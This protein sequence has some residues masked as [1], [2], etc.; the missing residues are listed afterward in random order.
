[1]DLDQ[2]LRSKKCIKCKKPFPMKEYRGRGRWDCQQCMRDKANSQT[3]R[4]IE[5]NKKAANGCWWLEQ[6]FMNADKVSN[7]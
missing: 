6:Y 2:N 1:M 4:K 7:S 3:Q 5:I